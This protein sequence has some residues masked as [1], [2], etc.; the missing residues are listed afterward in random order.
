MK[1]N[2]LLKKKKMWK[3]LRKKELSKKS[4]IWLILE[5][6]LSQYH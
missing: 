2:H 5:I 3:N 1:P 6:L 4:S